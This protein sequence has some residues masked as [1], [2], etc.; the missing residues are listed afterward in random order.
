MTQ[1]GFDGGGC[2]LRWL[3]KRPRVAGGSANL[4][5]NGLAHEG[6]VQDSMSARTDEI[7]LEVSCRVLEVYAGEA[8][9]EE[10]LEAEEEAAEAAS[11]VAAEEDAAASA[12]VAAEAAAE[13]AAEGGTEAAAPTGE[14]SAARD[15]PPPSAG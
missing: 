15:T 7:A 5:P 13:A 8:V 12:E 3:S 4:E 2:R 11:E 9:P 14:A 6:E 10:D 1:G